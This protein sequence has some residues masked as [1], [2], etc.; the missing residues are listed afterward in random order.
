MRKSTSIQTLRG[1]AFLSI[2]IYH[3]GL[4]PSG[5]AL[6]VSIFF[7]LSGFLLMYRSNG[8]QMECSPVNN[9]KYSW[10]HI[11]KIYPLHLIMSAVALPILFHNFC[12]KTNAALNIGVRIGV[13]VFLIQSWFPWQSI[14]YSM[15]NLSWFLSCMVFLYF[16]FPP[17]HNW[18]VKIE[19]IKRKAIIALSAWILMWVLGYLAN[20][21][22]VRYGFTPSFCQGLTYNFPIYRMGDFFIGCIVGS[23][24]KKIDFNLSKRAFTIIETVVLIISIA[25]IFVNWNDI[26]FENFG[27]RFWE[28]VP[29]LIPLSIVIVSLFMRAGGGVTQFMSS[30]KYIVRLGDISGDAYLI[31]ELPMTYMAIIIGKLGIESMGMTIVK[32][33]IGFTITLIAVWLWHK[34]LSIYLGTV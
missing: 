9:F 13:N 11:R 1:L 34:V 8:E 12:S 4:I 30:T 5:G 31:H 18:L 24:Y 27:R 6:G 3:A 20:E 2:F 22:C 19:G 10:K 26:V 29:A 33:I 17:I 28:S 23:V 32:A 21:F 25:Y 15:N 16:I 14:R 7:V